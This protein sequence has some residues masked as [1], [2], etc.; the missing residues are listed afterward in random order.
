MINDVRR[1]K[2]PISTNFP[3]SQLKQAGPNL[4][5]D[6]RSVC[7][8]YNRFLGQSDANL[9][10]LELYALRSTDYSVQTT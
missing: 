9:W 6:E 7:V 1:L 3:E 10:G 5:L 8:E 2:S 4:I